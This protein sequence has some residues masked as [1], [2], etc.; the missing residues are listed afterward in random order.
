MNGVCKLL[1]NMSD[2]GPTQMDTEHTTPA[3][4]ESE[5]KEVSEESEDAKSEGNKMEDG[6]KHRNM[7]KNC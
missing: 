2:E 5:T 1:A 7:Q 6:G 3:T 4:E